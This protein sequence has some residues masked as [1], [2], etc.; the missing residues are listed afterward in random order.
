MPLIEQPVK[1]RAAPSNTKLDP[2]IEACE[3][4]PQRGDRDTIQMAALQ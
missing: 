3:D 1:C 4:S 2:G